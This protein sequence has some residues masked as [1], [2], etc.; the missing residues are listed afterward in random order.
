MLYVYF[1]CYS[2]ADYIAAANHRLDETK[3][4]TQLLPND[5]SVTS[6][7]SSSSSS[8]LSTAQVSQFSLNHTPKPAEESL[9][10]KPTEESLPQKG[11]PA[12]T[13][14]VDAL[15]EKFKSEVE[16]RMPEACTY[17]PHITEQN[18]A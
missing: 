5:S 3:G 12:D 18:P 4:Q 16:V 2:L 6:K 13:S 14:E 11:M 9:P 7:I 8:Q 1:I 17:M 10:H 15:L